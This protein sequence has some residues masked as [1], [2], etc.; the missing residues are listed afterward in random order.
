MAY[1]QFVITI[2]T[3]LVGRPE[4]VYFRYCGVDIGVDVVVDMVVDISVDGWLI[5]VW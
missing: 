4:H 1:C 3:F 5:V 2:K